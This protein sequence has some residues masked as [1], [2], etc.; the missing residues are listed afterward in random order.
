MRKRPA[1]LP[2][3]ERRATTVEAVVALAA[4]QN[5]SDITTAAIAKRMGVTQ[6]ALFRHFPSKDAILQAVMSWVADHLLGRIDKAAHA[7][8][9]PLASLE[10]MFMAHIGFVADH[11]GVP[12]MIFGELQRPG[13]TLP[14]R[15]VETMIATYGKRLR[16]WLE[17]GQASGEIRADLDLDA[18][19]AL[20]IGS[21]QGLVLQS[22]MSGDPR[23]LSAGASD[24]F[25]IYLRGIRSTP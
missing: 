18:A 4:E 15:M 25:A 1:H 2:A 14:K 10:A 3:E 8:A 6:G 21:V 9:S 20:F 12:R 22:L 17:A 23:R 7:A 13:D 16:R 11:P 19:A 5:P 24:V